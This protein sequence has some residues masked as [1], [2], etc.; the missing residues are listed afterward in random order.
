M[1]R[2]EWLTPD[3]L[4]LEKLRDELREAKAHLRECAEQMGFEDTERGQAILE[5][6]KAHP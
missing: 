3:E 5:W 4:S 1:S 2:S 6:L